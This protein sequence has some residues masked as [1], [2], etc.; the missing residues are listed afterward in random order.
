MNDHSLETIKI[1]Q[2]LNIKMAIC[3]CPFN[4]EKETLFLIHTYQLIGKD[5]IIQYAQ[6]LLSNAIL[7]Y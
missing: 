4:K 1:F 5:M 2:I 7:T 3:L 6:E